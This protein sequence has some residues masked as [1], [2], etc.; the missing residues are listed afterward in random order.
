MPAVK[1]RRSSDLKSAFLQAL[2]IWQLP[3]QQAS[4][5]PSYPPTLGWRTPVFREQPL[6]DSLQNFRMG[7]KLRALFLQAVLDKLLSQVFA[8]FKSIKNFRRRRAWRI[9]LPVLLDQV[10]FCLG[11]RQRIGDRGHR[12]IFRDA[13]IL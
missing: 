6:A 12:K 9:V 8:H 2:F 13:R 1:L 3:S 5:P 7:A 11:A 10:Q 4:R